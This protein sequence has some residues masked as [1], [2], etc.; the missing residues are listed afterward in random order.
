MCDTYNKDD[1]I[2]NNYKNIICL[3]ERWES[4][5]KFVQMF[6]LLFFFLFFL[7]CFFLTAH[8]FQ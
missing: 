5:T 8:S 3:T 2:Y 1:I 7:E 4:D 6:Q